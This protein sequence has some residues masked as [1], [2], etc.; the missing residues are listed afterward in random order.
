VSMET[1]WFG[2]GNRG[3]GIGRDNFARI[4]K[5]LPSADTSKI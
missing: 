5:R 4:R 3:R 1:A 2:Y